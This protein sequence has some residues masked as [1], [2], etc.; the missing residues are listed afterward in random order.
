[1][2]TPHIEADLGQIAKTVL[3]PGDPLRA[4]YIAE[5]F[6][7]DVIQFNT[8]RNM[9]GYTGKY[10]GKLV[11]VMGSGMGMPSIGIY[12]YEL[13]NFYNVEKI[14]RIGTCGSLVKEVKIRDLIISQGACSD[15]SYAYQF[16]LP[17]TF[18]AI[19]SFDLLEK[20]VTKTREL[21]LNY[22]VGNI[23]TS[24]H[25]Y[26]HHDYN[27]SWAKMGCLAV[28]M[29][30]Y[31]LYCQAALA[32]KQAL[33]ILTVSDSLVTNEVTTSKEREET[34]VEMMKVALE[35]A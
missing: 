7:E 25:F 17:G 27:E 30:T 31:A 18:S 9:F 35:I 34:F 29:E 26:T 2:A 21:G 10:Q 22:H 16:D 5:N 20:A 6:L 23:L 12:S 32:N 11:S 19:S 8:T 33:T 13:F 1:M 3:M 4:K 14:I 24:D 28:E 15:S